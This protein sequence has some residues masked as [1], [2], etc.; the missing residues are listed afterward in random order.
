MDKKVI[1][2]QGR[3]SVAYSRGA[4]LTAGNSFATLAKLPG[5]LHSSAGLMRMPALRREYLFTPSGQDSLLSQR[6]FPV[7]SEARSLPLSHQVSTEPPVQG[8]VSLFN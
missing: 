1:N 8:T 2:T 3:V 5:S 7:R 6:I 4:I